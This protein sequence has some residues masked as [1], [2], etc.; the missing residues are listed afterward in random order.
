MNRPTMPTTETKTNEI[1][2]GRQPILNGKQK[3]ISYEL[4]FRA[5]GE[6]SNTNLDDL[7]AASRVIVNLLSQFGIQQILS[8]KLGFLNIAASSLMIDTIELLPAERMVLEILED[9]PINAQIITRQSIKR[10]RL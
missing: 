2:L 4:L 6:N 10:L 3:T 7:S 8:N 1:F 5:K 9:I